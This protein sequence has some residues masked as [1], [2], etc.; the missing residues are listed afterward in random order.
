MGAVWVSTRAVVGETASVSD[1]ATVTRRIQPNN[2]DALRLLAALMVILG[3]GQ[4]MKGFIPTILWNFPISRIGL[5]I[6]FSISGYLVCDSWLRSPHLPTFLLKRALRIVPALFVCVA[7]T[8]LVLG[9]L[10]TTLPM[11][12]YF[13][14]HQT[15]GYFLNDLL[16]LKLNLPGVFA[17]RRLG[18]A[19]NGSLWSLFPEVLCY[20][21]IPLVWLAPR[22]GRIA[23]LLAIMAG[24]GFLGLW[25]FDHPDRQIGLVYS[26]DPKYVLV[27]VPFFMAGAAL[28]LVAVRFPA[29]FRL[30]IACLCSASLFY[31]PPVLGTGSVPYEWL[32]L[33]YVVIALGL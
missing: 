10:T 26:A 14:H 22:F 2:F 28:R 23:V 32:T 30:D 7:L 5:D 24:C 13:G 27:Q 33:A 18:G 29:M 6:F 19:V 9:P 15:W 4:D 17:A 31:L 8:A 11:A 1:S 21:V 12:K 3:H 20:M 16:Y 25:M